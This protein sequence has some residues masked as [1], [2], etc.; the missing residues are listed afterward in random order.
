MKQLPLSQNVDIFNALSLF[1]LDN[2]Y[3]LL[4]NEHSLT[5]NRNGLF[6]LR[7]ETQIKADIQVLRF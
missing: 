2:F 7:F 3:V 6:A 4:S 1:K 5:Y